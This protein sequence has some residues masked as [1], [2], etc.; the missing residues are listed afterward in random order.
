MWHKAIWKGHPMRLELE[1]VGI[2][3]VL[4]LSEEFILAHC[5]RVLILVWDG[6]RHEWIHLI[7]NILM[8][9]SRIRWLS[10]EVY[11]NLISKFKQEHCALK[12][13]REKKVVISLAAYV[14]I[15][16]AFKMFVI[17]TTRLNAKRSLS[18]IFFIWHYKKTLIHTFY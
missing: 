2:F 12:M 4:A 7:R 5:W 17:F 11:D 3:F 8:R 14:K 13:R 10:S 16:F 15:F 9:I 6:K 1:E 18:K